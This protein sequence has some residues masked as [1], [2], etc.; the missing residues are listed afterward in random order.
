M[1]GAAWDSCT[2]QT[3]SVDQSIFRYRPSL[4]ANSIFIALFGLSLAIEIVQGAW[5]RQFTFSILMVLGCACEIVGYVGRIM[6]Y[7]N[8]WNFSAFLIQVS[9][10]D[11]RVFFAHR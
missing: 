9:K 7:D 4:A 5:H 1:S 11:D 10:F 3:C 8:P 2:L 6:M